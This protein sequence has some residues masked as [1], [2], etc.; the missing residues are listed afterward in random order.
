LLSFPFLLAYRPPSEATT[1]R[2]TD[3]PLLPP[4]D[5]FPKLSGTNDWQYVRRTANF[6]SNGP[7]Q[8]VNTAAIRCYEA[9]GRSTA[10]TYPVQAGGTLTFQSAPNIFHPGPLSG[11][12]AKVP[13]GQTAASWDGSGAVWFKTY[14]EMPTGANGGLQF[15]S[16]SGSLFLSLS[17]HRFVA[18]QAHRQAGF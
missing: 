16:N 6:Q 8:D 11:W 15:A 4:T 7:V 14:Q 18:Q 5:T 2:L 1:S 13:A 3:P 12:M 9:G 17:P 10:Q